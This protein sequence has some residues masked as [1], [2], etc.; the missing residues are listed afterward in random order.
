VQTLPEPDRDGKY[1]CHWH[2]LDLKKRAIS[3]F[4]P[5]HP[6]YAG[7]EKGHIPAK[8]FGIQNKRKESVKPTEYVVTALTPPN[9]GDTFAAS[10]N[11]IVTRMVK[12]ALIDQKEAEIK[13]LT[14]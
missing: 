3:R 13:E 2:T 11:E 6:S 4:D 5:R 9:P 10:L 1:R 7:R 8:K 12:R 14:K